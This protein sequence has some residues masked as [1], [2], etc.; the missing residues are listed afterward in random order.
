MRG[1]PQHTAADQKAAAFFRLLAAE[2]YDHMGDGGALESSGTAALRVT[3]DLFSTDYVIERNEHERA[4]P[5]EELTHA[6][7]S[8]LPAKT[9]AKPRLTAA[10]HMTA[11]EI[12]LAR[13]KNY[14]QYEHSICAA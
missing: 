7:E 4:K 14:V 9:K 12:E 1:G 8:R 3:N 13:V 10:G 6:V 2:L 11:L 5:E